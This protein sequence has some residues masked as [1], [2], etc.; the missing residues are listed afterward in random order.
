METSGV[1]AASSS[2]CLG[3][4]R[5]NDKNMFSLRVSLPYL[6]LV[7][8]MFY[9][10]WWWGLVF[11]VSVIKIFK[12]LPWVSDSHFLSFL[13]FFFL[14][15]NST[16]DLFPVQ[17]E[18]NGK[19]NA[20]LSLSVWEPEFYVSWETAPRLWQAAHSKGS[21]E[22]AFVFESYSDSFLG[23]ISSNTEVP[24]FLTICT[25]KRHILEVQTNRLDDFLFRPEVNGLWAACSFFHTCTQITHMLIEQL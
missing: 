1:F 16:F 5:L 24:E 21:R 23:E 14:K 20:D 13:S 25:C 6:P 22:H 7:I 4:S 12:G 17:R 9:L 2:C 8:I 18:W 3:S 19:L 11:S 10:V 15:S